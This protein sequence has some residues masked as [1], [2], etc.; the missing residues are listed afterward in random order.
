MPR[1]SEERWAT[2]RWETVLRSH[3]CPVKSSLPDSHP[4]RTDS[5]PQVNPPPIG[6]GG[7]GPVQQLLIP[8]RSRQMR[9]RPARIMGR[10]ATDRTRR[11]H[12]GPGSYRGA[13][14]KKSSSV[15]FTYKSRPNAQG[16]VQA[17][18]GE[19]GGPR[20]LT[21]IQC[22][23]VSTVT[24]RIRMIPRPTISERILRQPVHDSR[25]TRMLA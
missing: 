15:R 14:E 1:L 19:Q 16:N 8:A 11:E 10:M 5:G 21:Y 3:N 22:K 4:Y 13:G 25:L 17:R 7:E 23:L 6:T 9:P 12:W 2:E 20:G 24:V 18:G